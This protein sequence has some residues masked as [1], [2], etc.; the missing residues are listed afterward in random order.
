LGS[1]EP[2]TEMSIS[3]IYWGRGGGKG[4]RCLGLTLPSPY[5]DCLEI[6][7]PQHA[8]TLRARAGLYTDCFT[9]TLHYF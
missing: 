6:W 2:L 4:G 9:F 7:E 1:T 5:A 8:E 3:N